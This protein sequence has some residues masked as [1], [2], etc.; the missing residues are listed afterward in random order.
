MDTNQ[1]VTN[2]SK[3]NDNICSGRTML[4]VFGLWERSDQ[5]YI[6]SGLSQVKTTEGPN[7]S[8][9]LEIDVNMFGPRLQSCIL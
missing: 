4:R 8:T 9:G 7:C 6:S 1:A 5:S 2:V 3:F